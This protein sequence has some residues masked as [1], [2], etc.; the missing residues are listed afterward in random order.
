MRAWAWRAQTGTNSRLQE[1]GNGDL[2]L[3][4]GEDFVPIGMHKWPK[5]DIIT[6]RT[7]E[8]GSPSAKQEISS[9]VIGNDLKS[10][11]PRELEPHHQALL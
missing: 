7:I 2:F 9:E 3:G 4:E 8:P 10:S 5:T 1:D 11:S 6:V